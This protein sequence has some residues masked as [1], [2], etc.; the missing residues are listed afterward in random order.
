M[1]TNNLSPEQQQPEVPQQLSGKQKS[2]RLIIAITIVAIAGYAAFIMFQSAPKAKRK[3][4]A[5]QATLVESQPIVLAQGGVVIDTMGTIL[6][7]KS[8]NLTSEVAGKIVA[9]SEHFEPGSKINKGDLIAQIDPADYRLRVLQAESSVANI[10]ANLKIER[11][12]QLIAEQEFALLEGSVTAEERALMLRKAQKEVLEASLAN[13]EAVL[14]QAQLNLQRT[15]IKAP[16]NGMILT[17]TVN[18]GSLVTSGTTMAQI[19]GSDAAWVEVTVPYA[20][21]QQIKIGDNNPPGSTAIINS[22]TWSSEEERQGLVLR[23]LPDIEAQGL[24]A[25]LLVEIKDPFTTTANKPRLMLGDYVHVAITGEPFPNSILLDRRYLR[26]GNSVWLM[27]SSNQLEIRP[28][29][30][31]WHNKN[32]VLIKAGLEV[33]EQI[34]TSNIAAPVDGMAL[35][36]D[37]E[38]LP[39]TD[40][41]QSKKLENQQPSKGKKTNG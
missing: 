3:P 23:L 30:I 36:T 2:I 29:T 26:N 1:P 34:I 6:A 15:E 7:R 37:T 32:S 24:M 19:V 39:N 31:A 8:I 12:Q 9:I 25:R 11:G 18:V 10:R 20:K 21:L 33:G 16:F 4:H 27:D 41:V 38:K 5:I 17:T 13:A 22:A 40:N 14:E 35:R 28:I